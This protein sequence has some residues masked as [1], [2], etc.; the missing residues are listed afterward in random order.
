MSSQFSTTGKPT[1]SSYIPL[2]LFQGVVIVMMVVLEIATG[3]AAIIAA[4]KL[5]MSG[6]A[7]PFSQ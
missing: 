2:Q 7:M 5:N 3:G 1:G 6:A 4:E